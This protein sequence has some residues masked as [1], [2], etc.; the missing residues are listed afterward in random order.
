MD[1]FLKPKLAFLWSLFSSYS[2]FTPSLNLSHLIPLHGSCSTFGPSLWPFF[3]FHGGRCARLMDFS[4]MAARAH[5]FDCGAVYLW[6]RYLASQGWFWKDA[7]WLMHPEK[8]F[9]GGPAGQRNEKMGG[10]GFLSSSPAPGAV[11][12]VF[13][14]HASD[15]LTPCVCKT[16]GRSGTLQARADMQTKISEGL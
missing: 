4:A 2:I 1:D 13:T 6:G 16:P 12:F 14:S 8:S 7:A 10:S 3:V 5:V 15:S 9:R 11:R